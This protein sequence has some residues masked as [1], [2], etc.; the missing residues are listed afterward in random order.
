MNVQS[1][2]C[3]FWPPWPAWSSYG[4]VRPAKAD[5]R[6][7]SNATH[8]GLP[9]DYAQLFNSATGSLTTGLSYSGTAGSSGG[10]YLQSL[11]Y[12][13]TTGNLSGLVRAASLGNRHEYLSWSPTR[14]MPLSDIPLNGYPTEG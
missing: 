5:I 9:G 1:Y 10:Y 7:T 2:R 14:S 11:D 13:A 8:L 3:P 6:R 12:D 4:R